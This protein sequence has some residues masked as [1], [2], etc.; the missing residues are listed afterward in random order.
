MKN[1]LLIAVPS[2]M[3]LLPAHPA[4]KATWVTVKEEGYRVHR[5][6]VGPGG[7][8][9]GEIWEIPGDRS[10]VAKCWDKVPVY[11]PDEKAAKAYIEACGQ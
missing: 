3:F 5:S 11:L 4:K 1:L 8:P 2:L 6:Y 7:D 10:F 9:L